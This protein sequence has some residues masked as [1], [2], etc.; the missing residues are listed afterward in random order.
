MT[1]PHDLPPQKRGNGVTSRAAPPSPQHDAPPPKRRRMVVNVGVDPITPSEATRRILAWAL[2]GESRYVCV[3]NVHMVMEAHDDPVF[4]EVI[5]RADLVVPDG[6]PLVWMLKQLGHPAQ[7]R[8]YG[9][10]LMLRLCRA[11]AEHNL[12]VGLYGSTPETLQR[13][14][15]RLRARFPDLKVAYAYSPPFRPLTPEEE[16]AV[17]A[18]IHAAGVRLLF[19]ALG[20][21][22]QERWMVRQKGELRLP[23]IGVGAAFDFLAG[24][25]PQAP[26]WMQRLGLEWLFRLLT[27]PRRLLRRYLVH[28]PRFLWLAGRQ[29]CRQRCR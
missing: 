26:R 28:N 8:V 18:Q 21:P 13:L 4:R 17:R 10:D 24:T 14:Q 1:H 9:P 20:C 27:E 6:M 15:E 16:E 25:K 22:K 29:L 3:A 19:V 23:M 2:A 5:N 7:P 12:P 11:A